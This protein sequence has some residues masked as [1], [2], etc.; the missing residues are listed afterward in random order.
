MHGIRAEHPHTRHNLRIRRLLWKLR[1]LC[2]TPA[3]LWQSDRDGLQGVFLKP[4][5]GLLVRKATKQSARVRLITDRRELCR[6]TLTLLIL[7]CAL[8][9]PRSAHSEIAPWRVGIYA[10][11]YYDTDP[12]ELIGG[13]ARFVD[14]YLLALNANKTVWQS[15]SWPLALEI[16]GMLGQ[17][18]GQ[19]VLQEIGLAPLLRWNRFPWDQTVG[20]ALRFAPFGISYTTTI[21]PM[22]RGPTGQGSQTLNLMLLELAFSAPGKPSDDY[23]VRLHHR[24]NIYNVLNNYGANGEDF[25]VFG[26]RRAF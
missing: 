4:I 9:T 10:G 20:T 11:S 21:G 15:D 7:V 8:H 14:Q 26:Y 19:G 16:D 1:T 17:Q 24:C 5:A 3:R 13:N 12:G 2:I 23:F 6:G 18:T 22:E 25:L